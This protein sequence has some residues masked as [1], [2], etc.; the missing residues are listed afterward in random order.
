MLKR[1]NISLAVAAVPGFLAYTGVFETIVPAAN[2]LFFVLI[3]FSVLSYLL[4]LFE[5]E[6]APAAPAVPLIPLVHQAIPLALND[7]QVARVAP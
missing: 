5:D 3:G 4:S 7:P 2:V 6:S 1:G